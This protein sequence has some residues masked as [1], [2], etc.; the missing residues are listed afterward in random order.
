LKAQKSIQD[1]V[2]A[3][4]AQGHLLSEADV[5]V[6]LQSNGTF[7]A[8]SIVRV[9]GIADMKREIFGPVLHVATYAANELNQVI[10]DINQAAYGLT[11]GLHTRV[12]NR[13]DQ[14]VKRA[15]MGNIYVN[16]N[17]IGAVVGAQP[18]G[19]EGLSGTGP[20]A[21]GPL[22]LH[23]FLRRG[24]FGN[25]T[26]NPDKENEAK[27]ASL[28]QMPSLAKDRLVLISLIADKLAKA[29]YETANYPVRI[30]GYE[31][32]GITCA[33]PTGESN[34]LQFSGRGTV[35][36]PGESSMD[37]VLVALA[38]GN[39]VIVSS[40]CEGVDFIRTALSEINAP[41]DILRVLEAETL[42]QLQ[43]MGEQ[44]QCICSGLK[45]EE[46]NRKLRH[47]AA[48]SRGMIISILHS[49]KSWREFVSEKCLSI[50]TTASGGNAAL[51]AAVEE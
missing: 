47:D 2:A 10:D 24:G 25:L 1:Y 16:R 48:N 39:S 36:M 23:K 42:P 37:N 44:I 41:V 19:G 40:A 22:Y 34:T 8:P 15:H 28:P 29:G 35:W 30:S 9:A 3:K 5:P 50:D 21:G 38:V 49:G 13:V 6:E 7:V 18:F 32:D 46:D 51:L 45:K 26:P 11:M 14:V 31:P 4:T 20:K 12:N 17:Q 43:E 33:G 27:S